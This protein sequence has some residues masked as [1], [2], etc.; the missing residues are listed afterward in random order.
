[1]SSTQELKSAIL[2]IYALSKNSSQG[3]RCWQRQLKVIN[4][5]VFYHLQALLIHP[6]Y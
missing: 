4:P 6:G 1:M 2:V 3:K 5:S